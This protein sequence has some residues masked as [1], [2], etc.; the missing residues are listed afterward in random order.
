[1]NRL[2]TWTAILLA[3]A[4]AVPAQMAADEHEGP[5][6][7][8]VEA[9]I[10]NY[11]DGAGSAEFDAWVDS[12]NAWADE[13]G[14]TEYMAVTMVPFYHGPDQDFDFIWL[15]ASPTAASLGRDQDMW[16]AQG[17]ELQASLAEVVE[18]SS[19]SN[20]ASMEFKSPG[21][22]PI[23]DSL[24]VGFSDCKMGEGVSFGDIAPAM[25]EWGA[26]RAEEGVG[27]GIW[28]F[29]PAFGGGGEEF[30]FKYVA[31]AANLE[32]LGVGWD[33]YASGG[34]AKAEELFAD[35]LDCDSSRVYIATTRRRATP[36]AE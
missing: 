4:V 7:F 26:Y 13:A 9:Y 24:V 20:F 16:L 11:V 17:G 15:G 2:M 8:P 27:G 25:A 14:M 19:H 32:A 18:C 36:P 31:S 1:M 35:K 21:D 3:I 22:G 23:P 29:F 10:C 5:S 12:W 34:Y 33:Q 6:A 28:A 30:D